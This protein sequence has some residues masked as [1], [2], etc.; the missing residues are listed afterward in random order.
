MLNHEAPLTFQLWRRYLSLVLSE[1]IDSRL[2]GSVTINPVTLVTTVRPVFELS[3]TRTNRLPVSQ[4][5]GQAASSSHSF[6][7][8][9]PGDFDAR[10]EGSSSHHLHLRRVPKLFKS[11]CLQI[12]TPKSVQIFAC[13]SYSIVLGFLFVLFLA[14]TSASLFSISSVLIKGSSSSPYIQCLPG[15]RCPKP[16]TRYLILLEISPF[17]TFQK[18]LAYNKFNSNTTFDISKSYES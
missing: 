4:S 15:D 2:I 16:E 12:L 18:V 10:E 6:V 9:S 14:R 17:R 1:L 13:H 5:H 3:P 8:D 11:F 7:A